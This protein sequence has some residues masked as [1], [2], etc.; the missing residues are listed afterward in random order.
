MGRMLHK[1]LESYHV[2]RQ[3]VG[4]E[5]KCGRIPRRLIP[6]FRDRDECRATPI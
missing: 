4:R 3:L 2:P 6:I 1:S 5:T